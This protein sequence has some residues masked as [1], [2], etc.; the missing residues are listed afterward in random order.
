MAESEWELT[1]INPDTGRKYWRKKG[2]KKMEEEKVVERKNEETAF[3]DRGNYNADIIAEQMEKREEEREEV[4]RKA[5]G[6]P[7]QE[8]ES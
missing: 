2:K 4:M 6:L 7:P 5:M 8:D 3:Y 1:G